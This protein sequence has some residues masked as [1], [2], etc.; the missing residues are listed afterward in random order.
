VTDESTA[1]RPAD[2]P[3]ADGDLVEQCTVK[4]LVEMMA[5]QRLDLENMKSQTL[6]SL[7]MCSST[8][9][10]ARSEG[11]CLTGNQLS[12]SSCTVPHHSLVRS[13]FAHSIH[14]E[15]WRAVLRASERTKATQE[16]N[17]LAERG[18]V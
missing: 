9:V 18:R 11:L 16:L 17:Y 1:G 3:G 13:V 5:L 2:H 7:A 14:I 12:R 8:V 10:S 15:C 6:E 4:L